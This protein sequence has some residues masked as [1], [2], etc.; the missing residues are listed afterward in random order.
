MGLYDV[1]K[2]MIIWWDI[3]MYI[4]SLVTIIVIIINNE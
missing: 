2:I 3:Y 4:I 1:V